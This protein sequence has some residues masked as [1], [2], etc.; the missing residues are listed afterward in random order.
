MTDDLNQRLDRIEAMLRDLTEQHVQLKA[1]TDRQ[2]EQI[3]QLQQAARYARIDESLAKAEALIRGMPENQKPV[4]ESRLQALSDFQALWTKVLERVKPQLS[5][6]TFETWLMATRAESLDDGKLTVSTP[7][8]F[9]RNWVEKYYALTLEQL[10]R[11]IGGSP[12]KLQFVAR[13]SNASW[14]VPSVSSTLSAILEATAPERGGFTEQVGIDQVAQLHWSNI[15]GLVRHMALLSHKER[16]AL[17]LNLTEQAASLAK[18]GLR[19][20]WD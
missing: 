4:E 13:E 9:A 18:L 12:I 10:V 1:K 7:H 3:E 5:A 11:E 19:G 17:A 15:Q 20:F 14:S 2:T 16:A 8:P 6:A